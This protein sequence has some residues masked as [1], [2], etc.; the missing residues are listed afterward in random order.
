MQ[1]WILKAAIDGLTAKMQRIEGLKEALRAAG[2]TSPGRRRS[3]RP[4]DP[5]RLLELAQQFKPDGSAALEA[6]AELLSTRGRTSILR[7]KKAQR[8]EIKKA[9]DAAKIV[10]LKA[11][12]K[13][14]KARRG[15]AGFCSLPN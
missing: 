4:E 5:G 15:E 12:K 13:Q 9:V 10:V 3:R 7:L 1:D 14:A 6:A 2:K 8:E 11:M